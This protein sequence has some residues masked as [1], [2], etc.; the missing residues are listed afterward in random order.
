MRT[1]LTDRAAAAL[2][3]TRLGGILHRKREEARVRRVQPTWTSLLGA[4]S[5]GSAAVLLV[6]GVILMFFYVPSSQQVTYEGGYAPLQGA[7][8]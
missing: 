5:M 7:E 8:V 2:S 4:V 1:G 3:R 6:T